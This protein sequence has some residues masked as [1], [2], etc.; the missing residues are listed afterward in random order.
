[1]HDQTHGINPYLQQ[2]VLS[3]SL[4]RLRWMLVKRAQELCGLIDQMWRERQVQIADQWSIRLRDILIEL[5]SGV[6]DAANPVSTRVA[7][8]YVFLLQLLSEFERTR[9]G[10]KLQTLEGLLQIE[11]ETWR[12]SQNATE[13]RLH[14][15]CL[16]K[17]QS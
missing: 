11:E 14:R 15:I 6:Q 8:F 1:M 17:L 7:D 10:Q 12:K 16:S 2:E 13:I 4:P 5:L 9:D 3:A